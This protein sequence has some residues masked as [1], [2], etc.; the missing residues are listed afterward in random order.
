MPPH[1]DLDLYTD[2][3]VAYLVLAV[4]LVCAIGLFLNIKGPVKGPWK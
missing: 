2:I 4:V 1:I 3:G